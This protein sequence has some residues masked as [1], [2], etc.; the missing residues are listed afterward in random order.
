MMRRSWLHF[1]LVSV[2]CGGRAIVRSHGFPAF[3][4]AFSFTLLP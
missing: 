3:F 4:C 1:D 2:A